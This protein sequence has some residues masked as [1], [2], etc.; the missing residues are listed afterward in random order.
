MYAIRSYYGQNSGQGRTDDR[1]HDFR[2]AF[3]N[4]IP[5]GFAHLDMTEHIFHD[6][7]RIVHQ[8]AGNQHK[9]KQTDGVERHIP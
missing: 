2:R 8:N 4:R 9:G 7:D 3:H 5:P 6:D 1:E